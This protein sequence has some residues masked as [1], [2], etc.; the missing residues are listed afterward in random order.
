MV[1]VMNEESIKQINTGAMDTTSLCGTKYNNK[2]NQQQLN[3]N[4]EEYILKK[5]LIRVS[6]KLAKTKTNKLSHG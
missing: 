2:I 6:R 1:N 4:D 5:L 3:N